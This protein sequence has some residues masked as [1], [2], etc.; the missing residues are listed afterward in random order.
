MSD[1]IQKISSTLESQAQN[2]KEKVTVLD[3]QK[4]EG[5]VKL[6]G[7]SFFDSL[8]IAIT[9]IIIGLPAVNWLYTIP[10]KDKVPTIQ[11]FPP[12]N[13]SATNE[14]ASKADI[15]S[16]CLYHHVLYA[17]LFPTMVTM[18]G[19][20]IVVVHYVWRNYNS[21][22]F[23]LFFS[24]V[25]EMILTK[26]EKTGKYD[27]KNFI[28]VNR[29]TKIF[30]KGNNIYWSYLFAKSLQAVSALV[31]FLVTIF[32]FAYSFDR[33]AFFSI[34]DAYDVPTFYCQLE[35]FEF[36]NSSLSF[37]NTQVPCIEIASL[38]TVLILFFD[39]VLLF[40]VFV[41]SIMSM[42]QLHPKELK[43]HQAAKFSFRTGMSHH[44]YQS[45]WFDLKPIACD[46]DFLILLL[47]RTDSGRANALWEVRTLDEIDLFNNDD[48]LRSLLNHR[49]QTL[50]RDMKYTSTLNQGL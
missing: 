3:P 25:T 46:L 28:I 19:F 17:S 11:C 33:S 2:V 29:L 5:D 38:T 12:T 40:V 43:H 16:I 44:L 10:F 37:P 47:R 9:A 7:N 45:R 1:I 18:F 36:L 13:E 21:S 26:N 23:N 48:L 27:D 4:F 22:K 39:I 24:L 20:W 42:F 34:F 6:T 35:Q 31:A 8:V 41:F 14:S 32:M 15:E 50:Q 49:Q 30:T